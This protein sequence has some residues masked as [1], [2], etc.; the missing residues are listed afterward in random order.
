MMAWSLYKR[1]KDAGIIL[2]VERGRLTYD[3]P[4]HVAVPKDELR[5]VKREMIALVLGD[6]IGAALALT[7][8][9]TQPGERRHALVHLFDEQLAAAIADRISYGKACKTAYVAIG[10]Q[11]E[12]TS[13]ARRLY[14]GG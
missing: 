9:E 11:V 2:A 8:R 4:A 6:Y 12:A 5:H 7:L 3:A 1:C 14:G 10:K 13:K